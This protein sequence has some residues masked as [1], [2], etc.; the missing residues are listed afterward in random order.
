MTADDL[1]DTIFAILRAHWPGVNILY[2]PTGAIVAEGMNERSCLRRKS[3]PSRIL[4]SG[5]AI[6]IL[7]LIFASATLILMMRDYSDLQGQGELRGFF[8][9]PGAFLTFIDCLRSISAPLWYM[10]F[11]PT[12]PERADLLEMDENGVNRPKARS[13]KLEYTSSVLFS[14]IWDV[15]V[16]LLCIY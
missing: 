9:F 10:A 12:V 8:P 5:L 7:Y 16:V 2:N 1:L 11:P 4:N 6:H 15:V 14:A 3:F 13:Q